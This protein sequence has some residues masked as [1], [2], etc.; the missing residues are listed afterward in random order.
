MYILFWAWNLENIPLS[1][2]T[3]NE[4]SH[5]GWKPEPLCP[6]SE[7]G[8]VQWVPELFASFGCPWPPW[9]TENDVVHG[10]MNLTG[11]ETQFEMQENVNKFTFSN[12]ADWYK[13]C[14]RRTIET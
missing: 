8:P 5:V 7:V 13:I 11:P 2:T 6:V 1:P 3:W 9:V 12:K 14:I 4:G 10:S